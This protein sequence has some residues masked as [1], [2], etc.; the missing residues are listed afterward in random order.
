MA[1]FLPEPSTTARGRIQITDPATG[2]PV[3]LAVGLAARERAPQH[4]PEPQLVPSA[5]VLSPD[6]AWVSAPLGY[7]LEM[8]RSILAR[9]TPPEPTRSS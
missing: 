4:R 2:K 7:P 5:M 6:G 3:D 1:E 9:P 8:Y